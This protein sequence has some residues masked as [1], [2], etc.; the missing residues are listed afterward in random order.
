MAE[1]E[2]MLG[3]PYF[4]HMIHTAG[5]GDYVCL[6]SACREFA[7]RTGNTVFTNN[8]CDVIESYHDSSLRY[9]TTGVRMPV[10]IKDTHRAKEPGFYKNYYGTYLAALGLLRKGDD[11]EL[12]L[13]QLEE[14]EPYVVIQPYSN[15]AKNP[16]I[17]YVQELVDTFRSLTGMEVYVIGKESTHRFLKNVRYDLLKDSIVHLMRVV[18]N[19]RFVMTPR[20][21]SAHLAAG[22]H[23]PSF[24]W[25]PNDGENWH[26]DY[27][28]W[29]HVRHSWQDG[30]YSARE[31]MKEFL[32]QQGMSR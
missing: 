25:M 7:R 9:G 19:A 15:F 3:I 31:V 20:S 30:I 28:R 8:M 24:V 29:P 11:P 6:T 4:I 13:P 23:K 10:Y 26:L 2:E 18:Q 22:Y 27:S 16:N 21:C 14:M 5:A 1:M 32:T 17:N 12:D